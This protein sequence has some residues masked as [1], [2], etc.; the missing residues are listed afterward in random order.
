MFPIFE[1]EKPQRVNS[2]VLIRVHLPFLY[3]DRARA[4]RRL[5]GSLGFL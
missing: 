3:T 4:I 5:R 2:G 1:K